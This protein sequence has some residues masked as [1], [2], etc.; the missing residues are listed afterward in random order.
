MLSLAAVTCLAL[1]I[2]HEARGESI[3][4]QLLVAEV[5]INRANERGMSTCEVVWQDSQFSW[6]SDGR[7]DQP[8]NTEAY[9]RAVV[10][11]TQA[12]TE[13][14]TLLGSGANHYHEESISP[15]WAKNMI[16]IGKYGH[17]VFYKD[18]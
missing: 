10:L 3:D 1:N 17:H 7:S 8:T 6:T 4:A 9:T 11:A 16:L 18:N 12:L 14:S 15:Q 13:P 2:Y 5:T